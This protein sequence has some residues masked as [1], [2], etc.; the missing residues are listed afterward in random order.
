MPAKYPA[1]PKRWRVRGK[2]ADGL[3]VTLGRYD[4]EE[5]AQA[6]CRK[7]I[8]EAVY[9]DLT[10]QAIPVTAAPAPHTDDA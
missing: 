6:D 5:Q 7:F 3:V 1:D 8:E 10:V 9:R 2:A 4:T